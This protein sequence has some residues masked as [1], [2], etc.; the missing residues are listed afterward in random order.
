MIDRNSSILV[1]GGTGVIGSELVKHL[2]FQKKKV[3]VF[4]HQNKGFL[5]NLDDENLCFINKLDVSEMKSNRIS[6]IYDLAS[7]IKTNDFSGYIE[8]NIIFTK[9]VIEI[10]KELQIE[11]FI[12]TSTGSIFSRVNKENV[13][14][15]NS[16]P[17]PQSYYGLTKFFSEK[18]LEIEFSSSNIQVSV[19]RFPSVFGGNSEQ[20]IVDVFYDS[21]IN[22]QNIEVYSEGERYR[23]LLHISSAV[24]FLIL[25]TENRD[26]L[27]PY[28]IFML[29]SNDSMKMAD[30]SNLIIQLTGSSSKTILVNKYP[31]SDFDVFINITKAEKTLGFKTYSIKEGIMKYIKERKKH[32]NI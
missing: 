19:V 17:T 7:S 16:T 18:M 23:N 3:Y 12:Y 4:I 20:S 22:N 13:F 24:E 29:G 15:E 30:I 26:I 2:I 31:P 25:L 10:A 5:D 1:L 27:N 28:E 9:D 6:I 21:A 14:D 8:S 11:Q 32:E